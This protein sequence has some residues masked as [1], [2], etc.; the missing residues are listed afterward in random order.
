MKRRPST[1]ILARVCRAIVNDSLHSF[2][3]KSTYSYDQ[4]YYGT[5]GYSRHL[6]YAGRDPLRRAEWKPQLSRVD[7]PKLDY[8]PFNHGGPDFWPWLNLKV[9]LQYI[10]YTQFDGGTT[11]YD[12]N[13]HNAS[14]N[15]TI[16]AFV[17]LAF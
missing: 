8:M 17:W 13:G 12:G 16:Y 14:D 9:G 1:P 10:Y 6:R 15:N 3:V 2:H 4:T 7:R 11:N 5:I